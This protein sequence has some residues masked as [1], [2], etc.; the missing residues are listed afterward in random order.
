MNNLAI[1]FKNKGRIYIGLSE[2]DSTIKEF[3]K[4]SA[5]NDSGFLDNTFHIMMI[6]DDDTYPDITEVESI[7][8]DFSTIEDEDEF[9]LLA[10]ETLRQFRLTLMIH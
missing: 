9:L 5:N 4:L 2:K 1:A 10:N 3:S 8:Y 7:K 6:S